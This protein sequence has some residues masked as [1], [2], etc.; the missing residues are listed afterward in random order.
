M[1]AI[2][3]LITT[4][5]LFGAVSAP[6]DVPTTAPSRTVWDAVYSKAQADRGKKTYNTLCARCHGDALM[7]NDDAPQ[8]VDK[9]FLDKWN[10]KSVGSL[11]ELTRKTMPTDGPG[12]VTRKQCTDIAAYLLNSNSFP[13]GE[14]E[15]PPD[16]DVLNGILIQEKK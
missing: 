1:R 2:L 10:G 7:G 8:L 3:L 5:I 12:K 6:S 11:V 14:S 9:I 15:L 13:A 4:I 16:V